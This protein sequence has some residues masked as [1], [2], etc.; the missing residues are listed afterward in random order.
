MKKR[1]GFVSQM[2]GN[3]TE[4]HTG[5]IEVMNLGEFSI[6]GGGEFK[7]CY[8]PMNGI[9]VDCGD[10][11]TID[12]IKS[13]MKLPKTLMDSAKR[14]HD[15]IQIDWTDGKSLD[16][17]YEFWKNLTDFLLEQNRDV[18]VCCMGGHGR[19]GT[20]LSILA[21]MFGFVDTNDD[22]VRFVRNNYCYKAVETQ[23]QAEYI[24]YITGKEVK[25][26]PYYNHYGMGKVIRYGQSKSEMKGDRYDED[27]FIYGRNWQDIY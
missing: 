16:L 8:P 6:F 14:T 3:I 27:D 11:F 1:A 9:V 26:I 4:C 13:T 23:S 17:E 25:E 15:I 18:L 21:D 7:G 5:N 22:P 2:V 10:V 12:S 24:E 20:T 19:T